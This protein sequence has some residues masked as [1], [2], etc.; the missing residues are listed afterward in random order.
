MER[1]LIFWELC[2]MPVYYKSKLFCDTLGESSED[3]WKD[4]SWGGQAP[5]TT[6]A[7]CQTLLP[8]QTQCELLTRQWSNRNRF[9]SKLCMLWQCEMACMLYLLCSMFSK[10]NSLDNNRLTTFKINRILYYGNSWTTVY[11]I[12]FMTRNKDQILNLHNSI[13]LKW[14]YN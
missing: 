13:K 7:G 11:K 6:A 2:Q 3:I 4:W 9:F 14:K 12:I 1:S 10:L 5:L 8:L